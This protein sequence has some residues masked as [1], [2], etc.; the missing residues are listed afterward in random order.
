VPVLL[1]AG[2]LRI[3]P[4]KFL[5]AVAAGRAIRFTIDALLGVFYGHAIIHFF[6][7]YYKPALYTLIAL[8]VIGGI[9]GFL[10]YKSW[11]QKQGTPGSRPQPRAA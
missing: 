4:K 11:K 3:P 9:G 6:G 5:S 2:A 8:G 10:Y 1:A 7:Q